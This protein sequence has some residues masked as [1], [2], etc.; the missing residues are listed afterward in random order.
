MC[1]LVG[2]PTPSEEHCIELARH[3]AAHIIRRVYAAIPGAVETIRALHRQ[4]YTLHTASGSSSTDL[5][6]ILDGMGVRDCF[7]HLYGPDLINTFKNGP[8]YYERIFDDIGLP[9]S[10]AVVIDDSPRVLDWAAQ[11]GARTI[12][13]SSTLD[14]GV[15][16]TWCVSSLAELPK[17]LQPLEDCG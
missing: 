8:T 17:I 13:V 5:A 9:P 16:A 14:P 6:A 3:A 2:V 15:G 12:L 4:G 10:N 1:K 11:T 7:G